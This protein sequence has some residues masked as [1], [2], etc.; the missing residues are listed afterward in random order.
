MNSSAALLAMLALI[1]PSIAEVPREGA[2]EA[3]GAEVA[4][5]A[6]E[7]KIGALGFRADPPEPLQTLEEALRTPVERQVRIEQRVI[8][9][10]SPR[11][12]QAREGMV[13]D[14]AREPVAQRYD[15]VPVDGCVPLQS[16]AGVQA[17]QS[18]RLLLFL[19]DRRMLTASLER[20]CNAADFYSGF[21]VER[22]ADGAL[23]PRRDQLQSR[24]GASCQVS[25]FNRLVAAGR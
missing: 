19:R 4:R 14:L 5:V 10:I 17:S 11:A 16:I 8:I 15:E 20:R 7:G 22:N 6:P 24:A 3:R 1:V 21:Y 25:Q 23:C 13:A 18:G 9:R 2:P 12:P